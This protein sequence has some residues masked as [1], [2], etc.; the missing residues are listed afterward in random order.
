[1]AYIPRQCYFC[2]QNIEHPDFKDLEVLKKFVSGQSKIV[3]P[4]YT[5]TCAR[6]QRRLATAI[7]RARFLG[8]LA[9]VRR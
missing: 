4:K 2:S 3:D 6:H 8:L 7:K 5:S 1:M 9:F